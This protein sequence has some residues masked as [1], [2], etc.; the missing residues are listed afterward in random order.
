MTSIAGQG[1][2]GPGRGLAAD[3]VM[4]GTGA[5]CAVVTDTGTEGRNLSHVAG[6]MV[7]PAGDKTAPVSRR[8]V[9]IKIRAGMTSGAIAEIFH[10]FDDVMVDSGNDNVFGMS[11]SGRFSGMAGATGISGAGAERYGIGVAFV[12]GEAVGT[13]VM[14]DTG[15]RLIVMLLGLIRGSMTSG[16][17]VVTIDGI[18]LVVGIRTGRRVKGNSAAKGC[19]RGIDHVDIR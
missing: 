18:N 16:A 7:L 8:I 13:L 11:T 15:I 14:S 1:S 17:D 4:A 19:I 10:A 5:G 2:A 9:G 12:A 6:A 3:A